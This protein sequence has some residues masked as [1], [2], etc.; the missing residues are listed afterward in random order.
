MSSTSSNDGGGRNR[1][2]RSL[3]LDYGFRAGTRSSR[4]LGPGLQYSPVAELAQ[5]GVIEVWIDL[6]LRGDDG[7]GV[8]EV[9][10]DNIFWV[11]KPRTRRALALF[12]LLTTPCWRNKAEIRRATKKSDVIR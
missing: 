4:N 2:S 1:S 6:P 7:V 9:Q 5:F 3:E 11:C 10:M 12:L 8:V